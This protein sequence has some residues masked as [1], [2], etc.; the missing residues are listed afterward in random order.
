MTYPFL[1]GIKIYT[2]LIFTH[3]KK[4]QQHVFLRK[5]FITPFKALIL[6]HRSVSLALLD[7]FRLQPHR[8]DTVYL[9]VDVVVAVDET[10]IPNLGADLD[11]Q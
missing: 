7:E 8:A 3:N 4:Q 2:P 9:A 11:D 1:A 6:I 5:L 10:D